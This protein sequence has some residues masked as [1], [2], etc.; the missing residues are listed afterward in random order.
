MFRL[1]FGVCSQPVEFFSP[2]DYSSQDVDNDNDNNDDNDN[3]NNNDN[4]NP[5][6]VAGDLN[7]IRLVTEVVNLNLNLNHNPGLNGNHNHFFDT[8]MGP[9]QPLPAPT[10]SPQD[11]TNLVLSVLK[12]MPKNANVNIRMD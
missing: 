3:D 6:A 4:N 1:D 7:D 11:V 8:A 10:W 5:T 9:S 12:E 2:R